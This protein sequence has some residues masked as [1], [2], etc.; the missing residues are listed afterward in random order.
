MG[1]LKTELQ[2]YVA[3][4]GR[5]IRLDGRV[6]NVLEV[7][8]AGEVPSASITCGRAYYLGI[9]CVREKVAEYPGAE[10][11]MV[12]SGPKEIARLAVVGDR[13]IDIKQRSRQ[14]AIA[15]DQ[16]KAKLASCA[17]GR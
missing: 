6:L 11:W 3:D 7:S 9:L 2:R 15:D 1:L 17:A 16:Q 10:V 12:I 5:E 8:T 14:K 4:H 13:V